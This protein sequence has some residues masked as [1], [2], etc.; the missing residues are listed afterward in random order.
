MIIELRC[1]GD[2]ALRLGAIAPASPQEHRL[3]RDAGMLLIRDRETACPFFWP[4][5]SNVAGEISSRSSN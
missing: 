2:L 5:A 1:S 4:W 3:M